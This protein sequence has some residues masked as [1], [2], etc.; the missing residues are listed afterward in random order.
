MLS[1]GRSTAASA[2][3]NLR[4]S[5]WRAGNDLLCCSLW[6]RSCF[7]PLHHHPSPP[8]SPPLAHPPPRLPHH[9][10]AP[11]TSSTT[12][13][14]W[15]STRK[16]VRWQAQSSSTHETN[17]PARRAINGM[18]ML[19]SFITLALP[20][21]LL[22]GKCFTAELGTGTSIRGWWASTGREI[23]E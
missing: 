2:L 11:I 6:P 17:M 13:M 14:G 5:R 19:A 9:Q 3:V 8:L 20:L 16:Q 22:Q 21:P 18:N 10:A 1:W 12:R 23:P 4:G 7:P 15:T